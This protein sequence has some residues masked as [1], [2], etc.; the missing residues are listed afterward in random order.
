[1]KNK[2]VQKFFELMTGIRYVGGELVRE[3]GK[4]R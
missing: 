1:M 3:W 4:A 2:Q